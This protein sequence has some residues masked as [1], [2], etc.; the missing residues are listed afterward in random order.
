MAWRGEE[1]VIA[2]QNERVLDAAPAAGF[3]TRTEP[4]LGDAEDGAIADPGSGPHTPARPPH[5][6][7][8]RDGASRQGG[9]APRRPRP[10]GPTLGRRPGGTGVPP[11]LRLSRWLRWAKGRAAPQDSR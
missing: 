10:P 7:G 1:K 8:R 9:S 2:V 5:L 4:S 6:P 3:Q 11:L